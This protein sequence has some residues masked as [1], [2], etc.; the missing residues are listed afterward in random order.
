M[1]NEI[2]SIITDY[3]E[4]GL[5]SFFDEGVIKDLPIVGTTFSIIKLSKGIQDRIFIEKLKTF[6]ENIENNN[7]WKEKFSDRSECEKIS[8]KLVY[9]INSSDDDEKI[10][11]IAILFNYYVE[12]DIDKEMYFFISSIISKSYFPYVKMLTKISDDRFTND[13]EVYDVSAISHLQ[14]IGLFEY[15][16]T[17]ISQILSKSEGTIKPAATIVR[18]TKYG[19]ILKEILNYIQHSPE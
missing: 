15:S 7:K 11:L 1:K 10:K 19:L 3:G 4:L 16:G 6:I 14:S 13:G 17:T 2:I 8:K 18:I 9:L 12:G 5:D